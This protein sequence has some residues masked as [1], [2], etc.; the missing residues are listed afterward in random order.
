MTSLVRYYPVNFLS[1]NTLS[2]PSTITGYCQPPDCPTDS[3]DLNG[4]NSEYSQR[5]ID[6]FKTGI[7]LYLDNRQPR[8]NPSMY[9]VFNSNMAPIRPNGLVYADDNCSEYATSS[10]QANPKEAYHF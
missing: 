2:T 5:Q 1:Y 4:Y 3:F 6:Q 7:K 9:P 10:S 8:R